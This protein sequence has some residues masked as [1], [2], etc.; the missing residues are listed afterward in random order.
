MEKKL[1]TIIVNNL[2][3]VGA[4]NGA[5]AICNALKKI[6]NNK[7][8]INY[9]IVN[10]A[11]EVK[12]VDILWSVGPDTT[13]IVEKIIGQ[14]NPRLVLG[15]E[16]PYYGSENPSY[17][18]WDFIIDTMGTMQ[19]NSGFIYRPNFPTSTLTSEE[20]KQYKN[21]S[22]LEK[23]A[24]DCLISVGGQ[25][26][27]NNNSDITIQDIDNLI[28]LGVDFI[29]SFPNSKIGFTTSNRTND[30]ITQYL[31]KTIPQNGNWGVYDY[32]NDTLH[33]GIEKYKDCKNFYKASIGHA[34][35]LIQ[36]D[37]SLTMMAELTLGKKPFII[38]QTV[39]TFN[40]D[41]TIFTTR[42]AEV[43]NF[44]KE[45]SGATIYDA[46]FVINSTDGKLWEGVKAVKSLEGIVDIAIAELIHPLIKTKFEI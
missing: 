39:G 20:I 44:V 2:K 37:D 36:T 10:T 23:F 31:L 12:T 11:E 1:N 43:A 6:S 30:Q 5:V 19:A 17:T 40:P 7:Y 18:S 13:N 32:K 38:Y 3:K 35:G 21:D 26:P 33:I 28:H 41:G 16:D 25:D 9:K 24:P 42:R 15:L 45:K 22:V 46:R 14:H 27:Y 34:K 8:E 4:V 29:K